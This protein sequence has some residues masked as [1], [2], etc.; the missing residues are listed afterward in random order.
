MNNVRRQ[1]P[2]FRTLFRCTSIVAFNLLTLLTLLTGSVPAGEDAV[3]ALTIPEGGATHGALNLTGTSSCAATSCHGGGRLF[4]GRSFAAYQIW[5]RNDPHS[6]AYEVLSNDRS[7]RMMALLDPTGKSAPAKATDEAR[8]L[9]CHVT[10]E[11]SGEL[12]LP[13]NPH[14]AVDGVGCESCHGPAKQWLGLH[15]T[16]E[17]RGLNAET[18]KSLGFIDTSTD[19]AGRVQLCANC[20]VGSPGRDV[21]HDLIAAGHPRLDFEFSAFHA[22]LPK[23][24]E[25]DTRRQPQDIE[26]EQDPAFEARAWLTG[27]LVTAQTALRLLQHRTS[28][29]QSWPELSE[30][31][32]FSCHHDLKHDSWY[33]SRRKSTG[34][35]AW[36]TWNFG[37]FPA[38][39]AEVGGVDEFHRLQNL[40]EGSFPTRESVRQSASDLDLALERAIGQTSARDFSVTGLDQLALHLIAHSKVP[41]DK[42]PQLPAQSWDQ[43]AQLYLATVAIALAREK[44]TVN[45][46]RNIAIQNDL[47]AIRN[48]L[49]FGD[50]TDSPQDHSGSEMDEILLRLKG[51]EETLTKSD[52]TP[53]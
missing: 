24:W 25:V 29:G 41:D 52:T 18:K 3:L 30:Y 21:N 36:G 14:Q 4:E 37:T 23:H 38:L 6:R 9:N 45:D 40:M 48:E 43:A 27:Q 17:W 7:V 19:L 5:A 46:P 49:L 16:I 13:P 11:S 28:D 42:M 31:A 8:C 15:S 35:F 47:E 39:T 44:L 20:H 26:I 50:D 34:R 1:Q 2:V 33:H 32:C 12:L 22:N 51:I 53:R 10:T